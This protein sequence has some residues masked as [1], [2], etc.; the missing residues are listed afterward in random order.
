MSEVVDNK[1]EDALLARA[2]K[3]EADV[4]RL[5]QELEE[6]RRWIPV[7]DRLPKPYVLVLVITAEDVYGVMQLSEDECG[8]YTWIDNESTI[9]KTVDISHWRPLP[10]LP[11]EGEE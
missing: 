6:E 2:E 7:I 1:L 4:A 8:E 9:H 10:Q 3:A 5:T 11:K